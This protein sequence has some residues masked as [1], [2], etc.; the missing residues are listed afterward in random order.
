MGG[1]PRAERYI[2]LRF[3]T[4]YPLKEVE[5][6]P[7]EVQIEGKCSFARDV[8]SRAK[9]EPTP[10]QESLFSIHFREVQIVSLNTK[11]DEDIPLRHISLSLSITHITAFPTLRTKRYAQRR[12]WRDKLLTSTAPRLRTYISLTLFFSPH[13]FA[14]LSLPSLARKALPRPSIIHIGGVVLL[15]S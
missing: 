11:L 8:I 13:M 3:G 1:F 7:L 6:M 5:V 12:G 15:R 4:I 14:S 9:V 2:S 10:G